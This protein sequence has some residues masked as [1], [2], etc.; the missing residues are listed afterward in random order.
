MKHPELDKLIEVVRELRNPG[1]GCPWDLKQTH[2][3]LLKYLLE[4]SYEFIDATEN[5]DAEK[6]KDELGDVLLQVLLH[7]VIAEQNKKF[8]LEDISKNLSEK[9]IR[10]HPHVFEKSGKNM[11]SEQVK[12]NWDIIK[13]REKTNEHERLIDE[14]YLS[15]PALFSANRIGEK[16]HSVRFDWPGWREVQDVV[17]GEWSELKEELESS[18]GHVHSRIEEEIGDLLFS[19]AQLARHLKIHPEEALR[20][21]NRKFIKRFQKMEDLIKKENMDIHSMNQAEMDDYW[22]RIKEEERD[23]TFDDEA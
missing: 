22:D 14:G 17:E 2:E 23:K 12:A 15:F 8:N 6:M 21:A 7:S 10:R 3:S 20:K 19:V 5:G 18:S 1:K 9:L 13:N 16:T 4:E 11:T